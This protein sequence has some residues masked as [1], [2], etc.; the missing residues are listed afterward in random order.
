MTSSRTPTVA[1]SRPSATRPGSRNR[2]TTPGWAPPAGGAEDVLVFESAG[3]GFVLVGGSGRG[4]GWAG[5]VELD[6]A[7]IGLVGRAWSRGTPERLSGPRPTRIAGPYYA[8]HAVAVPV[9]QRHVVVFGSSSPIS[10]RDGE[11]VA[12]AASAAHSAH[13]GVSADKLL[14]D[15]LEVVHALR[16]LMAYRP[17]TVRDTARHIATTA[18][19]AL[20]CE[21][22]VIRVEQDGE[23]VVEGLDLR[24]MSPLSDPDR[25][26]HLAL[27]GAGRAP[28]MEQVALPEPDLF[29]VD[30]A[31]RL[32]LPLAGGAGALALGHAAAQARGFTSLCQRIGRAIAEGA[33]LLLSQA[34]T[35]EQ[36]SAE[37]DL[38]ARMVRTD[39]L[40]GTGNRRAWDDTVA[41]WGTGDFT[42]DAFLICGDIDGLKSTNDRFGHAAGDA[43]IRGA[44]NLLR[45]CVRESDLVARVGGDEFVVVLAPADAS[46]A[47]TV[48]SRI[49]RAQ[50]AWRVTEHALA[51][52]LS[53][54]VAPVVGGDVETARTAADRSM[55]ANKR[56]RAK[57]AARQSAERRPRV[58]RRTRPSN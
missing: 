11:L 40:T 46:M 15:E 7:N 1:G 43:V 16:A 19:Q 51:P 36:L 20:S 23:A 22:A 44:A 58:D 12:L 50:R 47:R 37:R 24:S 31:S 41:E 8:P 17:V 30:V 3:E 27:V 57:A 25:D 54:G 49:R 21:V 34:A 39:A 55:Y 9:G 45:S 5:V 14:A 2:R 35:R 6:A 52:M 26:G 18:A 33:E 4:A 29:G 48:V 10:W 53:I 38:L 28:L 32:A 56:R 42:G 13:A